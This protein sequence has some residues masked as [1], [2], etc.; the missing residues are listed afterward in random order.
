MAAR[1]R[2]LLLDEPFGALDQRARAH[3][4][5]ELAAFLAELDI[6]ALVVTHDFEEAALLATEVAVLESR[7]I[8]QQDTPSRLAAAPASRFVADFT[9]AV[10]LTG[11][12]HSGYLRSI[13]LDGGGR[14]TS[15]DAAAGPVAV[16]VHPWE[17]SLER[18]APD[19]SALN[20]LGVEVVAVTAI[21]NRTRGGLAAPQPMAAE[22]TTPS[23]ERPGPRPGAR[24]FAAGEGAATPPPPPS[25]PGGG[26]LAH[27]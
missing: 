4:A 18:V 19:G 14:L 5:R 26:P 24:E 8:V 20:R 17:I 23:A 1:P 10:V 13:D 25:S 3:A 22:I 11:T 9:G 27:V 7:R 2:V 12:A 21:G 6:P 15:V 16:S